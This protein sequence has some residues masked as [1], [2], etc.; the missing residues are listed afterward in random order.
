MQEENNEKSAT[1]SQDATRFRLEESLAKLLEEVVATSKEQSNTMR[2][3][4]KS[5]ACGTD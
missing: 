4:L 2:S 5:Y 3:Q 1:C